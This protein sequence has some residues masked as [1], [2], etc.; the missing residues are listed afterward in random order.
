MF[1]RR[2]R[3]RALLLLLFLTLCAGFTTAREVMQN[4][5]C[6]IEADQVVQ[7]TLFV[8][9]D[10]LIIYG[11]VDGHVIGA[12]V[13]AH[14]HGTVA[15]NLYLVGA[16]LTIDGMIA[17]D[18]HY[19]GAS[20]QVLAQPA[21]ADK[22]V[23]PLQSSL[24]ALTLS[25]TLDA[26]T[27]VPGSVIGAGYQLVLNGAVG[28][29]VNYWGSALVVNGPIAGNVYA[30]VGDRTTDGSQIETL[31]LPLGLDLRLTTPG[32]LVAA[33]GRIEGELIYGGPQE[34]IIEG[35]VQ[36]APQYSP[37]PVVSLQNLEEP[38][39]ITLFFDNFLREAS[40]LLVIGV[41]IL[42]F[43]PNLLQTPLTNLRQRPFASF[44]VGMLSFIL[45][46][47]V[48]TALLLLNVAVVALPLVIGL[49][50]VAL[51]A[52]VLMG[53]F[54][55]GSISIFY[56]IAIFVARVIVA[57]GIGRL[58]LRIFRRG[59]RRPPGV[60]PRVFLALIIGVAI[61]ALFSSLPT[62]GLLVNGAAVF[63]GLG[64]VIGGLLENLR[65]L[66]EGGLPARAPVQTSYTVQ[67]VAPPALPATTPARDADEVIFA[68]PGMEDLPPGF[69][70]TSFFD[71][72]DPPQGN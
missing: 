35:A 56:F 26:G 67:P 27:R 69:D 66:R 50:G 68:G 11:E 33:N 70:P 45:S 55:V 38:G 19:L 57:L 9:C 64:T 24:F 44:S 34:A 65:R 1:V 72:D 13:R 32:L 49:S 46:F 4:S 2:Y 47:P 41:V 52:G 39:V 6:V 54:N 36:N 43:V 20:L 14:I 48:V 31:L 25:T 42:L 40:T 28:R 21:D 62:V 61:L 18:V 12:A 71:L 7:D 15:G 51:A 5:Q 63:F 3:R 37:P 59:R 60:R 10:D 53:L 17:G 58:V 16:A 30:S 29:E 22:A 23:S 8:L